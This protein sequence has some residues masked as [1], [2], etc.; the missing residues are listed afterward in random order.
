LTDIVL[1]DCSHQICII[2][3]I[4]KTI[5]VKRN[6][7][8]VRA[9][10]SP[11][12]YEGILYLTFDGVDVQYFIALDKLTGET[13]CRR[14]RSVDK[15]FAAVGSGNLSYNW[16]LNDALI[17][18]ATDSVYSVQNATFANTG[19]YHVLLSNGASTVQSEKAS[20]L[21]TPFV[22]PPSIVIQPNDK[23]VNLGDASSMVV[24][25][26]G[27]APLLFQWNFNGEPILGAIQSFYL[28]DSVTKSDAGHYTVTITN[29]AGSIESEPATLSL[30][31]PLI[32]SVNRL[33]W[34]S[35]PAIV[36]NSQLR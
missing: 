2:K 28:I 25:A 35:H 18:G 13:V 15:D 26:Q 34:Q 10:S 30:I 6:W 31:I 5:K 3:E 29:E 36:S 11:V 7:S 16:Y 23:R 21:V 22:E 24:S 14:D 27:T 12:V 32:L 1:V 17:E 8:K 19:Q 4:K 20:V 9:T 33:I